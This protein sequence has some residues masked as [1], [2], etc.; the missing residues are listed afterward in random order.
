MD[1]KVSRSEIAALVK[2]AGMEL[3]EAQFDQLCEAYPHAQRMI[4][5]V[6]RDQPRWDELANV[7][8]FPPEDAEQ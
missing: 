6:P 1:D 4:D 5:S 7:F 2:W 3:S 8:E